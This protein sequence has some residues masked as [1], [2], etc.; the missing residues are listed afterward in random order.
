MIRLP[1]LKNTA[2]ARLND[3]KTLLNNGRFGG[4][5]Y[6]CGYAVE[7]ALKFRSATTL[8]WEDA[9]P[10][11]A[12]EFKEYQSFKTHNLETLLHLSGYE[13][14][15]KLKFLTQWSGIAWWSPE[16]RY[17]PPYTVT[18]HQAKALIENAE[19]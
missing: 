1:D 10:D 4:A 9:F 5:A 14:Q 13:K 16:L 15:I 11:T 17:S 7:I 19:K 2:R 12:R 8:K 3:A 18:S 6:M